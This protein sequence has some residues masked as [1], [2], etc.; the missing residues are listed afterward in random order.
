MPQPVAFPLPVLVTFDGPGKFKPGRGDAGWSLYAFDSAE[1]R[2]AFMRR[3]P[4]G[5]M[6]SWTYLEGKGAT[7]VVQDDPFAPPAPADRPTA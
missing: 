5:R 4:E 3:H 2:T 1:A 6:P 7:Q